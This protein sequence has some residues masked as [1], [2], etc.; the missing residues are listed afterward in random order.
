MAAMGSVDDSD[1][2]MGDSGTGWRTSTTEPAK[3]PGRSLLHWPPDCFIGN[4]TT[5]S[6]CFFEAVFRYADIL[7]PKGMEAYRKLAS[8]EWK[9]VPA[10][11]A[12][13]PDVR[14]GEAFP[15][16]SYH[17]NLARLSH[18]PEALVAV[19]SRD[20]SHAY[21]YLRIAEIYYETGQH[22]KALEWAEQ[23]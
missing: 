11:T 3:K 23:G 13:E 5:A 14:L 1:G 20:L 9:K 12:N 17:G 4:C 16:Y 2:Y 19:M 18:D 21:S 10:R 8:A 6:M 22:D 7:G 15:D